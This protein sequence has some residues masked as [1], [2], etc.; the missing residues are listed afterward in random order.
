MIFF[1]TECPPILRVEVV[2]LHFWARGQKGAVCFECF[3][4]SGRGLVTYYSGEFGGILCGF[5]RQTA[6]SPFSAENYVSKVK[7][8]KS[9]WHNGFYTEN[10]KPESE[11][12]LGQRIYN[13]V[14]DDIP[15]LDL[16]RREFNSP[17]MAVFINW[18]YPFLRPPASNRCAVNENCTPCYVKSIFHGRQEFSRLIGLF[19]HYHKIM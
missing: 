6:L 19:A 5:C 13:G 17:T 12:W 18:K 14:V 9:L 4:F 7:C 11:V 15:T 8:C 16:L 1:P 2:I 10:K 3:S